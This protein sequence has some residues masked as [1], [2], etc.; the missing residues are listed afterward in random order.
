VVQPKLVIIHWSH[1]FR[2][3]DTDSSKTDEDRRLQHSQNISTKYQLEKFFTCLQ[4]VEEQKQSTHVIHSFIPNGPSVYDSARAVKEW[5]SIKGSSWPTSPTTLAE[6]DQL[7]PWVK[8]ELRRFNRY[9]LFRDSL[10]FKLE[11][12]DSVVA[13]PELEQIDRARDG[14]HYDMLT[15][16]NFVEQLATVISALPV[17]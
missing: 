2:D 13:I 4:S 15:A 6:F 14:H 11:F 12:K 10:E 1:F 3:E 16:T 8:N 5:N 7:M 9:N 17:Y